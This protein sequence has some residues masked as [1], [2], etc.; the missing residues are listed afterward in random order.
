VARPVDDPL[1][2][3]AV[4]VVR[5]LIVRYLDKAAGGAA[6]LSDAADAEA[7]HDFRVALRRLRATEAAYRTEL[8]NVF[9][10]KLRKR[11][12]RL[13]RATGPARDTEV[14]LAWVDAQAPAMRA[15]QRPGW[16]F[17]RRRLLARLAE[18]YAGV[19]SDAVREFAAFEVRLRDGL[20]S[21]PAEPSVAA[22][23][24]VFAQAAAD[25]LRP[26]LAEMSARVTS[27]DPEADDE[28]VHELRLIAKRARYLLDPFATAMPAAGHLAGELADWQ[29]RLGRVHDLQ[30]FGDELI[31]A[32]QA[33]GA[34]VFAHLIEHALHGAEEESL[35]TANRRRDECAGLIAL[36]RCAAGRRHAELEE[37][38]KK[39]ARGEADR[40]LEKFAE[41]VTALAAVAPRDVEGS[42]ASPQYPGD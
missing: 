39:I 41:L 32:A 34:S 33:A 28:A 24:R 18:E 37:V 35:K 20:D 38:W 29:D 31:A 2:L 12:R 4:A 36:A 5:G 8:A 10:G 26:L 11:L 22:E 9:T 7:L 6:R 21:A 30:V 3:P 23:S 16:H 13:A 19:R 42:G 27:L 1:G 14:Q 40:L 25:A 17:V 15:H